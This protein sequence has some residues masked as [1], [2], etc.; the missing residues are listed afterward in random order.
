MRRRLLESMIVLTALLMTGCRHKP[1]PPVL[2]VPPQATVA[3]VPAPE[4]STPP[5]V[6][7]M[8]TTPAPLP[9][10]T[11]QAKVKKPKKKIEVPA[12]PQPVQV[13]SAT[14]PPD[15]SVV[16]SLTA[17]G[18]EA[19][20]AKQ[21]AAESIKSVEKRLADAP[22]IDGEK[23]GVVQVKTFLRQA[24]EALNSGDAEGAQTLAT[25][26]MLLLDDL[27]K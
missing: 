13:A 11:V 15:L 9:N 8:P 12:D 25:K 6:A 10:K 18:D 23:H 21:K 17:G 2:A 16:G 4:P 22:R 20:A 26:A 7:T 5:Q 14:P 1:Q 19:P 24:H 3:L 27:L